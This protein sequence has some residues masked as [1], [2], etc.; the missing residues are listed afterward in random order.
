MGEW[1]DGRANK[2]QVPTM[3]L[4]KMSIDLKFV[5]LTAD[6][7]KI[8]FIKWANGWTQE[9]TV[10][11]TDGWVDGMVCEQIRKFKVSRRSRL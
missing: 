5:E 3:Q 6:V 1:M 7:L 2:L 9:W 10:G 4:A 8:F 11:W